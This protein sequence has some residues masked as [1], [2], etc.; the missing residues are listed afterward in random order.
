[1]RIHTVLF[2]LCCVALISV[3]GGNSSLEAADEPRSDIQEEASSRK[4]ASAIVQHSASGSIQRSIYLP[5]NASTS[6]LAMLLSKQYEGDSGVSV[7]AEPNANVIAIRASSEVVM[8]DVLKTLA[9]IDKPAR[10]VVF[11]VLVV[12]F[13]DKQ[14]DS[15]KGTAQPAV[16]PRELVGA[17]DAVQ[18]TLGKWIIAGHVGKVRRYSL[19]G[20]ENQ[21][22]SLR[23]GEN[24]PLVN[25][26]T[27]SGATRTMM[28]TLI[29]DE[30]GTT[31]E[32]TPRI[33]ETRDIV[34]SLT[35]ESS[36]YES[37]E[38]SIELAK[39]EKGRPIAVQAKVI[40]RLRTSLTI[41][42]GHA[43]VATEWQVEPQSNHRPSLVLVMAEIVSSNASR[44]TATFDLST[45]SRT[46]PVSTKL[47]PSNPTLPNPRP[48]TPDT[49]AD[50]NV[51]PRTRS[52]NTDSRFKLFSG[53]ASERVTALDEALKSRPNDLLMLF[54][55]S[56]THAEL[57][58]WE[59]A[60]ADA[61]AAVEAHPDQVNPLVLL[62]EL[63]AHRRDEQEFRRA[64][65]Q[66][67]DRFGDRADYG[68]QPRVAQAC[69][70]MPEW[71]DDPKRVER[72]LEAG[73]AVAAPNETIAKV[74]ANR[75]EMFRGWLQLRQGQPL[76]AVKT[77]DEVIKRAETQTSERRGFDVSLTQSQLLLAMALKSAGDSARAE[78]TLKSA[79]DAIKRW[80]EPAS[81]GAARSSASSLVNEWIRAEV[82]LRQAQTR[83][84]GQ[85]SSLP[86]PK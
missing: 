45:P 5:K 21:V 62:V 42:D 22:C 13:N 7:L 43:N 57:Q 19:T 8:Q 25:G 10:E 6:S 27:V 67:L 24:K 52:S 36:D 79:E 61:K 32:L 41:P 73:L 68:V 31:I 65:K 33:T 85:E 1:M 38:R 70:L 75:N 39:D 9:L 29:R 86:T 84:S 51:T 16:D 48:S 72:V 37:V 63:A 47:T 40:S 34:T 44:K 59:K 66:L 18:A 17:A 80:R 60:V 23:L 83:D 35:I 74:V 11:Q 56:L 20:H 4:G 58:Q 14:I 15:E 64:S 55:R 50:P 82:L 2:R 69:L 81:T 30:V 76:V 3:C 71:L 49:P 28:P 54:Q 12:E 26:V 53:A 78:A 46:A 77:L